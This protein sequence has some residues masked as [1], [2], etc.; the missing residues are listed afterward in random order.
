[1]TAIAASFHFAG[2]GETDQAEAMLARFL[3]LIG[4]ETTLSRRG[5]FLL[6]R[7]RERIEA[8]REP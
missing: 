4:D 8:S 7:M 2:A 6:R 5:Q 1:M 3:T